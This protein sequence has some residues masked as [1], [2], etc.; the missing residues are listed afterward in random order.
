[1]KITLIQPYFPTHIAAPPLGLGYLAGYLRSYGHKVEL[2]DCAA[3]EITTEKLVEALKKGKPNLIGITVF[4]MFYPEARETIREVKKITSVPVVIGGPHVS[5]LPRFSLE[6]TE[7]DFAVVGEGEKTL[8][9]LVTM[10]EKEKREFTA[11]KGLVFK[12]KT[13][14]IIENKRR[15]LIKNLDSLPLPAWDLIEPQ[16]YPPAPH[17]AFYKRFPIAPIITTRGCPY[18]CSFCASKITW[19]QKLRF[20][21]PQAVVDEI[22]LL[23]KKFGVKEFH[24]E[25]DNFTAS[26]EH[27]MAVCQEIIKRNLDIVWACPNGVRIDRLDEELLKTMK[28]SGC[29]LLAF[30]IE[31]SSQEI[32]DRANKDLDLKLTPKVLKMVKKV[33]IQ[34]WGFFII[35]LPGETRKTIQETISFAK[36]LPLDRAQFCKFTPLPGTI[37]FE[38]WR[39]G[40]DLR[41][42]PWEKINFFGDC[43]YSTEELTSKE[44][45]GFQ[46]KA[47]RAFYFRPQIFLKTLMCMKFRQF[48]WL[49]RR[50]RDY[51]Y[52]YLF[53]RTGG[54]E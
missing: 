44:L 15:P 52:F 54:N 3:K 45:T 28:K 27:A 7:A 20:R 51:F 14:K 50:L 34:T 48:K 11:V 42:L 35:G 32:L 8:L 10:I 41:D 46:K 36:K 16:K 43:V 26:R 17:G 2:F 22:E 19:E 30:G 12:T 23:V 24:F 39:E 47:F 49:L 25:D 4:T 33:G 18:N 38:E 6:D 13:G 37:I 9:E 29:Y 31:S 21:S 53:D 40:R 5:A 1:M